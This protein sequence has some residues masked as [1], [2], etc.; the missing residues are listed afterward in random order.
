MFN[1]ITEGVLQQI[2]GDIEKM[3]LEEKEGIDFSFRKIN[4][5]TKL[6]IGV[7]LS[8]SDKGVVTE[9]SVSYPLEQKQEPAQKQT[10]RLKKTINDNQTSIETA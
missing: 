2:T 7:V 5:G 6:S 3:L 8:P 10:I 4:G 9:Y 1:G